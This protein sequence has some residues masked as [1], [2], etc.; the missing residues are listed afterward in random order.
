MANAIALDEIHGLAGPRD[1]RQTAQLNVRQ[2][3][4]L[5]TIIPALEVAAPPGTTSDT[6][7]HRDNEQFSYQASKSTDIAD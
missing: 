7:P 2:R 5:P 1:M 3:I 6:F 4:S